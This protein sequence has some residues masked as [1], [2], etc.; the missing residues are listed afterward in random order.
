MNITAQTFDN[1]KQTPFLRCRD[2]K[3]AVM[4]VVEKLEFVRLV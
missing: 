3:D 4:L 1:G 2:T